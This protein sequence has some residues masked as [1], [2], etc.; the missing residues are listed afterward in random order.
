MSQD[1]RDAAILAERAQKLAA[2]AANVTHRAVRARVVVVTAGKESYGL[3]VPTLREIVGATPVAPLPGL[4]PYLC[5]LATV[6][7]ELMS[8]VDVGELHGRGKTGA[9]AFFAFVESS[10][11]A[12]ALHVEAVVGARDIFEDEVASALAPVEGDGGL[13]LLVTK[14]RVRVIDV[15]RLLSGPRLVV[16]KGAPHG[17]GAQGTVR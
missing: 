5:G 9:G 12:V 16:A 13:T 1:S 8:V 14:D 17:T 15:E 11:G 10:R 2:R 7:G 6:R 3:P 4:P